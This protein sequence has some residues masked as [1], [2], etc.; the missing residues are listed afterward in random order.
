MDNFVFGASDAGHW[1][2]SVP[3]AQGP[4]VVGLAAAANIKSGA[5]E[6]HPV[7][8]DFSDQGIELFQ[9]AVLMKQELGHLDALSREIGEFSNAMM[10]GCT[11]GIIIANPGP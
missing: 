9:V 3:V 4:G 7:P 5:V 2:L 6:H 11:Q 10:V 1:I 8:G